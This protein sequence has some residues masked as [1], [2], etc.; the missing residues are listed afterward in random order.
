[1]TDHLPAGIRHHGKGY[2]A[3]VVVGKVRIYEQFPRSTSIKT[4]QAWQTTQRGILTAHR[5]RQPESGSLAAD[6]Q[7]YL[8]RPRIQAMP[9]FDQRSQ[10]LAEWAAFIG[11]LHRTQI[12]PRLIEQQRDRWF[13]QSRGDAENGTELPP[14][15]ASSVNKRLRALSHVWTTLDGRHAPN[16]VRQVA[17]CG[18]PDAES[19]GLPYAVIEAILS[20]IPDQAIGV[21]KDGTRT[22]GK[23]R[24]SQTKARLRVIAYTGLSHAQLKA[25]QRA[26]VDLDAGT[27][28]LVARRKGK[29]I[30]RA[31][32]RPE[33]VL[34]PLIPQAVD[35]FRQFDRR[36]CW[37][38]FSNSSM[39]KA[40]QRACHQ[41]GLTGIRAYDFRHSFL[42]AVY[43]ETHDLRVTGRFGGHRSE[44]TTRRYTQVAVA[45]HLAAA[46]ARV[47]A[48]LPPCDTT[49]HTPLAHT[50]SENTGIR[51]KTADTEQA[52]RAP[53]EPVESS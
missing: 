40:F 23:A 2:Q 30:Q 41:I 18:E 42:S 32:D 37:G 48:I 9:T 10:H 39:W 33:P 14:Y 36:R 35:A 21:K 20:A 22:Q 13:Y 17:E 53:R 19:R 1:M 29:Q 5:V 51:R 52:A 12:T 45:P 11:H 49:W 8:A 16:P 47:Q 4:M 15:S 27:L 31:Q 7:A 34:V 28:R 25:L 44:R 3:R 26:D 38:S 43:A 50:T 46:A 24:P 6:I